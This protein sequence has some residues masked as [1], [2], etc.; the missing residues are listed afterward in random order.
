M[1]G[2]TETTIWSTTHHV[3]E[4]RNTIPIGQPIANTQVYILDRLMR[5][6][7][8][9]VYGELL[10][11]GEGVTR[12]YL[13]APQ[14]TAERFV[15]DPFSL[16]AGARLYKTG[17]LARYLPDGSIEFRRRMDQQV[18]LRGFRVE[19]GEIE[20]VLASHDAITEAAVV[21][22]TDAGGNLRLTAYYVPRD[23]SPLKTS[24]LRSFLAEYLPDHMV[25]AVYVSLNSLPLTP[26][27][28]LDRLA[29]PAQATPR[30]MME[31][32]YVMPGTEAERI[33]AGIWQE[34]LEVEKVGINDNFFDLG[35]HSL[36]VVQIHRKLEETFKRKLPLFELFKYP[37]VYSL[38][39]HLTR[40]DNGMEKK[41]DQAQTRNAQR[42]TVK[43]QR[44]F[45]RAFRT[46][47]LAQEQAV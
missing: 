9:G 1:Y 32:T 37:T 38:A 25:P 39:Q 27:G 22:A 43:Q 42:S 10:I 41:R 14:L 31:A 13:N 46:T 34:V 29:L 45:R 44:Q 15:P 18:K 3:N 17:D 35:G 21:A 26:N 6:V 20:A 16:N 5:P 47:K 23:D 24:D 36:L 11:G 30:P 12:G 8:I 2:P 40:D 33:I 19:L 28:K 4:F 7:P